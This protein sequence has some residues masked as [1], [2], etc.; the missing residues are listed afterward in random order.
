[1]GDTP[2]IIALQ[3][4]KANLKTYAMALG[5]RYQLPAHLM[6]LVMSDIVS[7]YRSAALDE[8]YQTYNDREMRQADKEYGDTHIDMTGLPEDENG[9]SVLQPESISEK[10]E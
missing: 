6:A 2:L 3:D 7:D 9:V 4:V 5:Q 8:L 1:M 10:H